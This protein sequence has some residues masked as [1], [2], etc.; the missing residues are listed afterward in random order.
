MKY[1]YVPKNWGVGSKGVNLQKIDEAVLTTSYK[2]G[3]R[4][5]SVSKI[6]LFVA[7]HI[8]IFFIAYLLMDTIHPNAISANKYPLTS[9]IPAVFQN[10]VISFHNSNIF[11]EMDVIDV[12]MWFFAALVEGTFICGYTI[13]FLFW[14]RIKEKEHSPRG[15]YTLIILTTLGEACIYAFSY[16]AIWKLPLTW[17]ILPRLIVGGGFLIALNY[18]NIKY[19]ANY[20][21]IASLVCN[22][23]IFLCFGSI[24]LFML[25][26]FLV[27]LALLCAII[28]KDDIY[29]GDVGIVFLF[30]I[31]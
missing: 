31:Y 9:T 1:K 25:Y 7:L 23:I 14:L 17:G 15:G 27:I 8:L 5:M 29:D 24:M 3:K 20:N 4:A 26:R 16:Y 2:V 10:M 22:I 30:W 13:P 11:L 28:F 6:I 21:F 18:F 19:V 12:F